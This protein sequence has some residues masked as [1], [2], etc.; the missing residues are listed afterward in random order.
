MPSVQTGLMTPTTTEETTVDRFLA[1]LGAGRGV[2]VDLFAADAVLDATVPGW[3]FP[4]RG[5][6]A[7]AEKFSAWFDDAGQFEEL[8]R[9]T[10]AGGEVITYTF[11]SAWDGQ[12]YAV[13]QCQVLRI[14]D[15]GRIAHVQ[16]WCGG[17]WR[18][19]QLA[20]MAAAA[21]AG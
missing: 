4:L 19:E 18:A 17:R 10:V 1:D 2:R 14:D 15:D 21:D 7:V 16:F 8:G 13:H 6:A 11:S 20:E 12:P 9:L 5:A 3:R